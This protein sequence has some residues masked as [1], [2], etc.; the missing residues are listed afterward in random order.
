MLGGSALTSL[1]RKMQGDPLAEA[2]LYDSSAG[3]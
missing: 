1:P 2:E 3:E